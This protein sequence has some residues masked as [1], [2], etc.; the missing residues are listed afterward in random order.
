VIEEHD[1]F[2]N[3]DLEE[4]H[5]DYLKLLRE[6]RRLRDELRQRETMIDVLHGRCE[7]LEDEN[8]SLRK[9]NARVERLVASRPLVLL[10]HA[11]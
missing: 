4:D 11:Q 5:E 9:R 8:R 2:Y 3:Q 10:R 6:N 7:R 1:P